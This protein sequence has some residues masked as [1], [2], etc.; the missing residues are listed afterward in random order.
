LEHHAERGERAPRLAAQAGA[1]DAD[2]GLARGVE[3]PGDEGEERALARAVGPEQHRE[4]AR[5]DAE[6]H[7]RSAGR[8]P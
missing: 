3:Q 5:Q 2:V 6:A 7:A 1:E 4:L 8:L